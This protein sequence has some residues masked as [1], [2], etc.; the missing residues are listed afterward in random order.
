MD[1]TQILAVSDLNADGVHPST[2]GQVKYADKTALALTIIE[3]LVSGGAVQR[4][5]MSAWRGQQ[6]CQGTLAVPSPSKV[7]AGTATD[8]TAGTYV[9]VPTPNVLSGIQFGAAGTQYT[10][11]FT[12]PTVPTDR[13]RDPQ[14]PNA[15][16]NRQCDPC[17]PDTAHCHNFPRVGHRG[18]DRRHAPLLHNWGDLLSRSDVEDIFGVVNVARWADLD[19]DQDATLK[20]ANRINRAIVWATAEMEDRLRNGPYQLPLTGTSATVVDLCASWPGCGSTRAAARKTS[21]PRRASPITGSDTAPPVRR[22]RAG[23]DPRRQTAVGC[24][25]SGGRAAAPRPRWSSANACAA[26]RV[27]GPAGTVGTERARWVRSGRSK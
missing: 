5:G 17:G 25:R 10:G 12:C 7:I 15:T 26:S 8:N 4:R 20:I 13:Q 18:P 2:A 21:T 16:A 11:V 19:N 6:E 23:R 14:F 3:D 27:R 1:G 22:D 9:E 24:E